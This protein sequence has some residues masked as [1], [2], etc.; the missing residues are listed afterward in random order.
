LL[1]RKE[2]LV[3]D[4]HF[5]LCSLVLLHHK[6]PVHDEFAKVQFLWRRKYTFFSQ[7]IDK[8]V[9]GHSRTRVFKE[10]ELLHKCANRPNIL[11]LIEYFETAENFYLVFEKMYGGLFVD[12][13]IS[14]LKV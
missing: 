7:I 11:Q 6:Q 4:I 13:F 14:S 12:Y 8:N 9:A 10:V 1:L 3:H 2:Q 5:L